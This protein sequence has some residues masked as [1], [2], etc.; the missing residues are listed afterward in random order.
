MIQPELI[1]LAAKVGQGL[2]TA[3]ETKFFLVQFHA[4][5]NELREFIGTLPKLA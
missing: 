1:A 3:A 4:K 2:A 5:V